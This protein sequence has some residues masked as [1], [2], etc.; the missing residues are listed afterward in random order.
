MSSRV[1]PGL[2]QVFGYGDICYRDR[3]CIFIFTG[4]VAA[5]MTEMEP[6]QNPA[7]PGIG[8]NPRLTA[9]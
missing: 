5:G 9:R 6:G 8:S 7:K 3:G 4:R 2:L 1:H